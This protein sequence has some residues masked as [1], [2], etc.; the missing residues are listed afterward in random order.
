MTVSRWRQELGRLIR[1]EIRKTV[2]EDS[3]VD[4]EVQR[5][6]AAFAR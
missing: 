1:D 2:S 4:D 3:E 6:I 5:M